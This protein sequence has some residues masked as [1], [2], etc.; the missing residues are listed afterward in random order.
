M[1]STTDYS[2]FEVAPNKP[3]YEKH[4]EKIKAALLKKDLGEYYPISCRL[5]DGTLTV[6][7]GQHRF[8]ARKE[9]GLPI[10]YELSNLSIEDER[11]AESLTKQWNM[12]DFVSYYS[13]MGNINYSRLKILEDESGWKSGTFYTAL[14]KSR[15]GKE[16]FN[17]GKF[18]FSEEDYLILKKILSYC[19]LIKKSLPFV[20]DRRILIATAKHLSSMQN[21]DINILCQ[22]LLK[23]AASLYPCQNGGQYLEMFEK[24]YNRG[25]RK[26]TFL[27]KIN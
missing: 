22:K 6:I 10:Y 25:S 3:F 18:I 8:A 14:G 7:N 15:I 1:K 13:S 2:L 21:F 12:T 5:F 26:K 16:L 23:N 24:I 27:R 19:I 11:N 17:E 20:P 4:K 9:L